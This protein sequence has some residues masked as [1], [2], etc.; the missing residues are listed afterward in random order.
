MEDINH[1]RKE[2]SKGR[3]RGT[4]EKH[5]SPESIVTKN[6]SASRKT[7]GD[8][9]ESEDDAV[10]S[11]NKRKKDQAVDQHETVAK[12]T[13]LSPAAYYAPK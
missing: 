12:K 11:S 1:F 4:W 5:A 9:S 2:I 6:R 8:H 10:S 13:R 3:V 7:D